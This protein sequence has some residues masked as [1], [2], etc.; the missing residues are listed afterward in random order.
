MKEQIIAQGAPRG[1]GPYSQGLKAG[2]L[3]FVSGQGPVDPSTGKVIEG[4]IKDQVRRTLNNVRAILEAAGSDLTMV[5][6]VNAYLSDMN[7]FP[8]FNEVYKEFFHEPYPCRT[9]VGANLPAG[10]SVEIDCI[11][12]QRS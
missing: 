2:N 4:S 11:A 6:K 3:I 9:T 12:I 5:V 7:D 8:A 10:F 1:A